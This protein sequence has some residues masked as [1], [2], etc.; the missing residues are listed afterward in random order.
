LF[1]G[2]LSNRSGNEVARIVVDR[3][4]SVSKRLDADGIRWTPCVLPARLMLLAFLALRRQP[5]RRAA[6]TTAPFSGPRPG[7]VE[8]NRV[9]SLNR[10]RVGLFGS[11]EFIFDAAPWPFSAPPGSL[12]VLALL[13]IRR[14]PVSRALI[15]ATLWP[16]TPDA[17]ARSNLRR[18]V[19]LLRRTL[20]EIGCAWI[21][22][23]G[24][25]LRWNHAAASIDVAEFLVGIGDPA[26][27]GQAAE[28]YRG[29][30][31]AGLEHEWLV[32]ER[33]RLRMLYL[34]ALLDLCSAARKQRDFPAAIRY[35]ERLL[36]HDD[37]R[38]DALRELIAARYEA[39]DRAVA[40]ATYERFTQQLRDSLD[41][42]PMPETVALRDAIAAGLPLAGSDITPIAIDASRSLAHT[43]S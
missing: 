3:F 8:P 28:L 21:A 24:G 33:E 9:A 13:A 27:A 41:V 12:L 26:R 40:L 5:P 23:D 31:L 34:D 2:C 19:H 16:D 42:E 39:G 36:F 32:V 43:D 7:C 25:R 38:E 30:L 37:L 20:P 17:E 35:A 22:D 4:V 18:Y 11:P 1:D 6:V 15:A 29:D 10:L 14:E